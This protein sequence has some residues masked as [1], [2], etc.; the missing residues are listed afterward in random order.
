M[1]TGLRMGH[2]QSVATPYPLMR[3]AVEARLEDERARA[4]A[5]RG[6]LRSAASACAR[7]LVSDFGVTRVWLF[8]SVARGD[9]DLRSDIDLAAEGLD[10]SRYFEALGA[11]T[12]VAPMA[13]DLVM[14]EDATAN[15]RDK[16]A[17]EGIELHP[18]P[19]RMT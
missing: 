19:E 10:P 6:E 16:I 3:R 9:V 7:L 15:L 17:A 14:V 2:A 8:G 1:R 13:L 12:E 11:L 5:R 18:E 4:L